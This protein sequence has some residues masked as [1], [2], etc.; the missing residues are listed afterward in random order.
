MTKYQDIK[1]KKDAKTAVRFVYWKKPVYIYHK[2]FPESLDISDKKRSSFEQG[3]ELFQNLTKLPRFY[4]QKFEN[5]RTFYL[6]GRYPSPLI[7]S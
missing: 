7:I 5:N 6:I 3:Q 1:P 2:V 4:A